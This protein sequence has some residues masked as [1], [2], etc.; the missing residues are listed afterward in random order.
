MAKLN[1]QLARLE[2]LSPAELRDEWVGVLAAPAPRLS[3]DLLRH[4]IAYHLQA[5]RLGGL[6]TK[7]LRELKRL[8][9]DP[10]T[11]PSAPKLKPGTRLLRSW[12]GRTI[13]VAVTEAGFTFEGRD[14]ASLSA[15]AREVTGTV[16]S[17][18]R[19]FGLNAHG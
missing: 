17:G 10:T 5:R 6:A 19:F 13:S 2:T 15:I 1:D 9:S 14:Y 18:P 7:Q 16:W 11:K 12:N 3:A 8:G 4:G